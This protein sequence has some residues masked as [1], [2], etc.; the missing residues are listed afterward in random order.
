M[1]AQLPKDDESSDFANQDVHLPEN[2]PGVSAYDLAWQALH[3]AAAAACRGSTPTGGSGPWVNTV[4]SR[5]SSGSKSC[6]QLCIESTYYTNCDAELSIYGKQG[7]ATSNGQGVGSFYNY[8]CGASH[9]GYGGNEA[10]AQEEDIIGFG[11]GAFSFCC[12]RK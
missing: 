7:K 2:D 8:H 9:Q 11:Q 12:C 10:E 6:T 1:E 4:L 3:A 5:S